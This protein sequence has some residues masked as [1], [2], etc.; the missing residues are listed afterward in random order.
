MQI[1]LDTIGQATGDKSLICTK[2]AS[3]LADI[4]NYK[5]FTEG[6]G[7]IIEWQDLITQEIEI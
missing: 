2:L 3:L 7:K 4:K 6:L 1:V 5:Q